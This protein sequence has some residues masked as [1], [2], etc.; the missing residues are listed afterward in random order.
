VRAAPRRLGIRGK[1]FCRPAGDPR[2]GARAERSRPVAVARRG[3]W[4]LRHD[5][6]QRLASQIAMANGP[7]WGSTALYELRGQLA[8]RYDAAATYQIVI[9]LPGTGRCSDGH[10]CASHRLIDTRSASF[11]RGTIAPGFCKLARKLEKMVFEFLFET[12]MELVNCMGK[13]LFLAGCAYS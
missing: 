13:G 1:I 3:A 4:S 10:G 2:S 12:K 7:G 6:R 9:D 8:L 11:A 5:A